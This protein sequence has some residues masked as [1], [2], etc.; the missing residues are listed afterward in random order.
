MVKDNEYKY[1]GNFHETPFKLKYLHLLG[2]FKK[3]ENTCLKRAAKLME[4]YPEYYYKIINLCKKNGVQLSNRLYMEKDFFTVT[5]YIS[6]TQKARDT[7]IKNKTS[8]IN[9][10]SFKHTDV[11]SASELKLLGYLIEN[12][13][14]DV[15][16]EID[17]TH[18]KKDLEQFTA[19]LQLTVDANTKFSESYLYGR[20][21]ESERWYSFLF[22]DENNIENKMI[23]RC[24]EITVIESVFDW[25]GLVN[26]HK[27]VGVEY[28]ENL[29]LAEGSFYNMVVAEVINSG[30]SLHDLDEMEKLILENLA[31]PTTVNGMLNKL[32]EYVEEDVIENHFDEYK[33]LVI[34]LL[35]QLV[36]KKAIKPLN[37]TQLN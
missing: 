18:L 31:E 24:D 16:K 9:G 19:S 15:I 17:E 36:L 4:L 37:N 35:K 5:E 30:F 6:Y 33:E 22:S 27:R 10:S 3:D 34:S 28:Y 32:K 7:Y 1:L 11:C 2:H 26:K 23:C 20:D 13:N 8:T 14:F 12:L 29:E 25:A 21:M